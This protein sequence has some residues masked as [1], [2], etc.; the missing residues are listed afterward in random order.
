MLVVADPPV[1]LLH[2]P[3]VADL[4]TSENSSVEGE[5]RVDLS[6]FR[7]HG[8]SVEL[9]EKLQPIEKAEDAGK[10]PTP[11]AAELHL[12]ITYCPTNQV[13]VCVCV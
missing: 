13:G 5:A 11:A 1:P 7:Q 10:T 4:N 3:V 9:W 8:N 6:K 12:T 2:L